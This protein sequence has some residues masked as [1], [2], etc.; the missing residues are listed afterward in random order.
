MTQRSESMNTFFDGY[1]HSDMTLKEFVNQFNN[2]LRKKVEVETMADFNSSN[3]MIPCVSPF[4]FEKQFQKVYSNAKFKE[5]QKELMDLMCCNCTLVS[6]RGCISTFNIMDEISIVDCT[7]TIHYTLYY[8]EEDC[9]LKCTC[10]LFE[11]GEILCRHVLRVFHLKRINVLPDRYVLDRWRKDDKR[12]YTL[13]QSSYDDLRASRD[14][15]RYEMVF[16]R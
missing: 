9:E 4:N 7:K 10:A 16:K 8:N 14:A 3:Q 6:K 5:F 12:R 11:M 13:I 2:T 1:V 15:Q